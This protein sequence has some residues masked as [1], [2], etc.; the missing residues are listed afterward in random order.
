MNR[1][2]PSPWWI[3]LL[4]LPLVWWASAG[5]AMRWDAA[6]GLAGILAAVNNLL[7]R[8][9]PVYYTPQTPRFL[10]LGTALYAGTGLV[11]AADHKKPAPARNTVPPA[12][13]M[14]LPCS[15]S[16]PTGQAP[17]CC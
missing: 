4:P 12:G 10:L 13:A 3:W 2:N 5:L 17:T 16:T 7:A 14:S 15:V 9:F 1:Q 8:P 11:L 6:A